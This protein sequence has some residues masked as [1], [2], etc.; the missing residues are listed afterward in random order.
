MYV[1]QLWAQNT[2]TSSED[3][4]LCFLYKTKWSRKTPYF[5]YKL[6]YH[7]AIRWSFN[8]SA[9]R[10]Q[11]FYTWL[12]RSKSINRNEP[13]NIRSFTKFTELYS[14]FSL[15]SKIK[16]N[17]CTFLEG[18]RTLLLNPNQHWFSETISLWRILKIINVLRRITNIHIYLINT[19]NFITNQQILESTKEWR[20]HF[21][22]QVT[23]CKLHFILSFWY[24]PTYFKISLFQ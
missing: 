6:V 24:I 9:K 2:I 10:G 19:I 4:E 7:V 16:R 21:S 15:I 13:N 8:A 3:Y 23:F 1:E 11:T 22:L 12:F 14:C 17:S 18:T 20:A 5:N